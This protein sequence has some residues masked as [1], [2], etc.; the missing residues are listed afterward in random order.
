MYVQ[1]W[2]SFVSSIT[3]V[4]HK[5]FSYKFFHSLWLFILQLESELLSLQETFFFSYFFTSGRWTLLLLDHCTGDDMFTLVSKEK[6]NSVP[7]LRQ[8][9]IP[10][11]WLVSAWQMAWVSI[12]TFC[13]DNFQF[14]GNSDKLFN[15]LVEMCCLGLSKQLCILEAP[16][17]TNYVLCRSQP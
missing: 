5:V 17:I 2:F 16:A 6:N 4:A 10:W 15:C 13:P 8:S 7:I 11:S 3:L 14:I 1:T 9:L 12:P